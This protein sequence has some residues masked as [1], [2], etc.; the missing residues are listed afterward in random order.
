MV[1]TRRRGPGLLITDG[2]TAK[3]ARA[4]KRRREDTELGAG[5]MLLTQDCLRWD[6]MSFQSVFVMS[7]S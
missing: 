2:S 4:S 1:D 3:L 5:H 7:M 6:S